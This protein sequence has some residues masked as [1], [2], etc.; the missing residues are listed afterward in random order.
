L[1]STVGE[2]YPSPHQTAA[3]RI[4]RRAIKKKGG[5]LNDPDNHDGV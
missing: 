3:A 5:G 4:P 2:D 1:V